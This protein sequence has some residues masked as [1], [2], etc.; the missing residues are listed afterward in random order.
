MQIKIEN[1]YKPLI[2]VLTATLLTSLFLLIG[3]I[4][5]GVYPFRD[6]TTLI[7]DSIH[8][9]LPFYTDLQ[10]KIKGG[11]SLLYSFAGGFGY[12]LWTTIAYYMSNPF[13]AIM[14]LIPKENV[15]DF[16]DWFIFVKI[17]LCAGTFSYYLA[18]K[19]KGIM[20]P[21]VFGT[22]YALNNYI[23]GYYYN[24][25]WLDS[26]AMLPLIMLGIERLV[27]KRDG[28]LYG[29]SLFF[30]IWCNYYIGFMLC[31]FS[32][33][34]FLFELCVQEK[35]E[36]TVYVKQI[37]WFSVYSLVAGG[38]CAVM[39][40]PTYMTL[41][42]SQSIEDSAFPDKLEFFMSF[43]E[44]MET[45]M[46]GNK[47]ISIATSQA[48]LNGYCGVFTVFTAIMT[49][50]NKKKTK[51]ERIGYLRLLA[52]LMFSFTAN[53]PNYIW[54]G[55]HVQNGIPNRFAFIF[56]GI[57]LTMA[58]DAMVNIR[59]LPATRIV[60][61]YGILTGLLIAG[62]I[63]GKS[64]VEEWIYLFTI[65]LLTVYLIAVL[66]KRYIKGIVTTLI[67]GMLF[68]SEIFGSTI[69][70]FNAGHGVERSVYINDQYQYG[71]LKDQIITDTDFYRSEID[72]QRMRNVSM[73]AGC[74]SVIMFN[75]TMQKSV[76]DFCKA[77]GMEARTNKNGYYG[78]T[79]LMNDVFG[80]R[81]VASPQRKADQFYGFKL[82]AGYGDLSLYKNENAL[83]LGFVVN[84][85]I[86]D[87]KVEMGNP[88]DIQNEFVRL[89]TG[90]GDL[91]VKSHDVIITDES[92]HEITIP[93]GY[94][95]Y[96]FVPVS[97]K[98][99]RVI[100]PEY[101]KTI[102]TYNNFIYPL[103]ATEDDN[104]A[105]VSVRFN[106]SQTSL[107]TKFYMCDSEK[108]EEAVSA[109]SKNQ[110]QDVQ[111]KGNRVSAT[112]DNSRAG[113]MIITTPYDPGW[114]VKVNGEKV[115]TYKVGDMF[116]GFD[117]DAGSYEIQMEY[118]PHGYKAGMIIS[119][120]S[121]L[122]FLVFLIFNREKRQGKQVSYIKNRL[123]A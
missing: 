93:D 69:F 5:I 65:A 99:I 45:M 35:Q 97:A 53:I 112:I 83:S 123:S 33:M 72:R 108:Y 30:G 46:P 75:S 54:H 120:V 68:V 80:I 103:N 6:Y 66:C 119:L 100:T 77:I 82:D 44:M 49:L 40:L 118:I 88:F 21:A 42:L 17:C 13:N 62:Y 92:E 86:K 94:Q 104:K 84:S 2:S 28:R 4:I 16:M 116:L 117:L 14:G 29:F 8:Q 90:Q 55:F 71:K 3:F 98:Q 19:H 52:I 23:I 56:I 10:E 11:D 34:Y 15:C 70:A 25:M 1:K 24:I 37:L 111:I 87:W 114:T 85:E 43:R 81:Y 91:F 48:G 78:V 9:Y 76:I 79:K 36:K 74:N 51:R 32:A 121:C 61:A 106:D 39:L 101:D 41:Q 18:K 107:T 58:C 22:A 27:E 50:F 109:L 67:C 59:E 31:I 96:M 102:E 47:P 115:K 122:L 110:L 12:N 26:V 73:F 63:K 64:E 95:M 7:I 38:M 113:T 89:A 60:P 57:L 105:S 20:F